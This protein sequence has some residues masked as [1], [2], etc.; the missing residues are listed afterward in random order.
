MTQNNIQNPATPRNTWG[1]S[2][3]GGRPHVHRHEV[4]SCRI[5]KEA[6]EWLEYK[7]G[8][9]SKYVDSIILEDKARQLQQ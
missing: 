8:N 6:K 9:I 5:S 3:G 2:R 7:A 4:L 1:G